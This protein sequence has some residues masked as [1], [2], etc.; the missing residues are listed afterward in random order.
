MNS[1]LTPETEK[2]D[3]ESYRTMNYL[4]EINMGIAAE[5][6][7]Y[8]L[9]PFL[10]PLRV[11]LSPDCIDVVWEQSGGLI[12][13]VPQTAAGHPALQTTRRGRPPCKHAKTE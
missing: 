13:G 9:G 10:L 8:V 2:M 12:G 3:E 6:G 5:G 1:T 7:L 11:F 4:F